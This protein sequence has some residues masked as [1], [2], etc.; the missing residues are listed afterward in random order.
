MAGGCGN[1]F[2]ENEAAVPGG[3]IDDDGGPGLDQ[4]GCHEEEN[5]QHG[6]DAGEEGDAG[7]NQSVAVQLP[8][9]LTLGEFAQSR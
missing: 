7:A 3:R 4:G 5:T 6:G 2:L 1:E 9:N 8:M